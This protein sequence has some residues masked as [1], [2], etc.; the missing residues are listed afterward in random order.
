MSGTLKS[1]LVASGILFNSN[2]RVSVV[3]IVVLLGVL[4]VWFFSCMVALLHAAL[5]LTREIDAAVSKKA[6]FLFT[7]GRLVQPGGS[8]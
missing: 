8:S 6:V 1:L 2:Y 3:I 5:R 4:R 7:F